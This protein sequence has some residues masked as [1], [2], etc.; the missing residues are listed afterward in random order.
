MSSKLHAV[1]NVVSGNV[2]FVIGVFKIHGQ[3]MQFSESSQ[4]SITE[5]SIFGHFEVFFFHSI[6]FFHGKWYFPVSTFKRKYFNETMSSLAGLKKQLFSFPQKYR[7]SPILPTWVHLQS[8]FS[9]RTD[10]ISKNPQSDSW[11]KLLGTLC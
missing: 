11:R 5:K 2:Y 7:F 10:K 8:R 9:Q 1:F 4:N 3:K 6:F